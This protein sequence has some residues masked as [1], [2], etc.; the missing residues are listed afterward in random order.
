[1][2]P[3]TW[4]GRIASGEMSSGG[5]CFSFD[6]SGNGW[7]RCDGNG[8]L[9]LDNYLD[10]VNDQLVHNES[11]YAVGVVSG[12]AACHVGQVAG[13]NAP[14]APAT[15]RCISETSRDAGIAL[16]SI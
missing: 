9:A 11:K 4:I 3:L 16:T 1:M 6:I 14:S 13:L 12:C 8:T 7:V 10:K 5:R 15:M 2:T